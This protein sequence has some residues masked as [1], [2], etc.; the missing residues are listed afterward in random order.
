MATLVCRILTA[1]FF[2][3][4]GQNEGRMYIIVEYRYTYVTVGKLITKCMTKMSK[5]IIPF[6]Q[7]LNLI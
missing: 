7:S 6:T 1:A 3:Q 5:E 4:I 2:V